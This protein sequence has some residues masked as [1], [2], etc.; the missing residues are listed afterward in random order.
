MA[1]LNLSGLRALLKETPEQMARRQRVE[2]AIARVNQPG[3]FSTLDELV[4]SGPASAT[5]QEWADLLKVGAPLNRAGATFRLKQDERNLVG[6]DQ[7]LANHPPDAP[8]SRAALRKQIRTA[9]P[10]F[11]VESGNGSGIVLPEDSRNNERDGSDID[12]LR[13]YPTADR[14]MH[15]RDAGYNSVPSESERLLALKHGTAGGDYRIIQDVNAPLL[16]SSMSLI[17]EPNKDFVDRMRQSLAGTPIDPAQGP[18]AEETFK[19]MLGGLGMDTHVSGPYRSLETDEAERAIGRS[20]AVTVRERGFGDPA[21]AMNP[22]A[23]GYTYDTYPMNSNVPYRTPRDMNSLAQRLALLKAA[24]EGQRGIAFAN[25]VSNYPRYAEDKI[26]G[27]EQSIRQMRRLASQYGLTFDPNADVASA[28]PSRRTERSYNGAYSRAIRAR[29]GILDEDT[30][31]DWKQAQ[32]DNPMS[33]SE[34]ADRL[35]SH[36]FYNST[37]E[38]DHERINARLVEQAGSNIRDALSFLNYSDPAVRRAIDLAKAEHEIASTHYLSTTNVPFDVDLLS[39]LKSTQ[40]ELGSR[41]Q[42]AVSGIDRSRIPVTRPAI[43]MSD[44]GR[45]RLRRIGI[46][47][48][49]AAGAGVLSQNDDYDNAPGFAKGR[50]VTIKEALETLSKGAKETADERAARRLIEMGNARTEIP[51]AFSTLD[52]I[53]NQASLSKSM[54]GGMTPQQWQNYLKP[55]RTV[56][57]EGVQFP[58]KG[59]EM[60]FT[61][62]G[63]RLQ[64]EVD[65]N[66]ANPDRPTTITPDALATWL[67]KYRAPIGYKTNKA[68]DV[69]SLNPPEARAFGDYRVDSLPAKRGSWL[70]KPVYDATSNSHRSIDEAPIMWSR[71]VDLP[72]GYWLTEAQHDA[73]GK[74]AD[75]YYIPKSGQYDA[76][77][78]LAAQTPEGAN[79]DAIEHALQGMGAITKPR[80]MNPGEKLSEADLQN[81]EVRRVAQG[82]PGVVAPDPRIPFMDLKDYNGM[83]LKMALQRVAERGGKFVALPS[84]QDGAYSG[85]WGPHFNLNNPDGTFLGR[86]QAMDYVYGM[87]PSTG[88]MG[89]TASSASKLAKQYGLGFSPSRSIVK[90]NGG[91]PPYPSIYGDATSF[92]SYIGNLMNE[93]GWGSDNLPPEATTR[94]L[95]DLKQAHGHYSSLPEIRSGMPNS[96]MIIENK[97]AAMDAALQDPDRAK[98]VLASGDMRRAMQMMSNIDASLPDYFPITPGVDRPSI[99]LDD[100]SAEK[101]KRIGIPLFKDGG[102]VDTDHT[103]PAKRF[104]AN[105]AENWVGRD[106]DGNV[107]SL[108]EALHSENFP[109]TALGDFVAGIPA[110][111]HD[112]AGTLPIFGRGVR[113]VDRNIPALGRL[114]ELSKKYNDK[115]AQLEKEFMSNAGVDEERTLG[116][117]LSGLGGSIIGLPMGSP[118]KKALAPTAEYLKMM[119][120]AMLEA[121]A[122]AK[123]AAGQLAKSVAPQLVGFAG[124]GA[125]NEGINYAVTHR[126]PD[127]H[128]NRTDHSLWDPV[129]QSIGYSLDDV[130]RQANARATFLHRVPIEDAPQASADIWNVGM[131]GGGS[132]EKALARLAKRF[133]SNLYTASGEPV[134]GDVRASSYDT[135]T[136]RP[137]GMTEDQIRAEAAADMQPRRTP[138]EAAVANRNALLA[139]QNLDPVTSVTP[140]PATRLE[141]LKR[142]RIGQQPAPSG[143]PV[144]ATWELRPGQSVGHLSNLSP[145]QLTEYENARLRGERSPDPLYGDFPQA[146]RAEAIGNWTGPSGQTEHNR[147]LISRPFIGMGK[148]GLA[149]DQQLASVRARELLRGIKNAQEASAFV[150]AQAKAPKST[151]NVAIVSTT[152]EGAQALKNMQGMLDVND[153]GA[154]HGEPNT[155]ALMDF[156]GTKSPAQ[157]RKEANAMVSSLTSNGIHAV[158]SMAK[159]SGDLIPIN[160]GEQGSGQVTRQMV[161]ALNDPANA[162]LAERLDASGEPA[163]WANANKIDRAASAASGDPIRADL[164][165]LRDMVGANGFAEFLNKIR[166]NGGTTGLGLPA[167][168]LPLAGLGG[169]QKADEQ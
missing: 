117:R 115:G 165:R 168:L 76:F 141:L 166:R 109:E 20:P 142:Q 25:Y 2:A 28:L 17:R 38:T 112:I 90:S 118:E 163:S 136:A 95:G 102:H 44:E 157:I 41:V 143:V 30:P 27:P 36:P 14:P 70:H 61:G 75:K 94:I 69:P 147:A 101:I 87:D 85:G 4:K 8:L 113:S 140:D 48:F 126:N 149:D 135:R 73:S 148:S 152:P 144:S 80:P 37:G 120:P 5:P 49:S 137:F 100:N 124:N 77:R 35:Y 119:A 93:T 62:L 153:L 122:G 86:S 128:L 39:R 164:L 111:I 54:S 91:K 15:T 26:Y 81:G 19:A 97:I 83:A 9:R 107:V 131:A 78:A 16:A 68:F 43:T 59:E 96:L 127:L 162:G 29:A 145:Q 3:I 32:N 132:V 53:I 46:P 169:P 139:Y 89:P 84:P 151:H 88:R 21:A 6:L 47:L 134:F 52:E 82:V 130:I 92:D 64:K 22:I 56:T 24:N 58:L 18:D 156:S 160:W 104:M 154:A 121:P 108:P 71:G 159:N 99:D 40:D 50:L 13:V 167:A 155:L 65:R 60:S 74:A 146:Q 55:G 106:K 125:V 31:F 150:A 63:D 72:E 158:H 138:L 23:H 57:R 105:W 123:V 33:Y 42:D 51:G 98:G 116:D 12:E 103:G 79:P 67:R 133:K 10:Q 45:D 129:D 1:K 66:A 34:M 114:F 110:A 7:M 11:V 161:E